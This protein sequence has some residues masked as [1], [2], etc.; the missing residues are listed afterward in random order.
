MLTWVT[1]WCGLDSQGSLGWRIR[2]DSGTGALYCHPALYTEQPR[3][4]SR[5]QEGLIW[6]HSCRNCFPTL[7]PKAKNIGCSL[8]NA[9]VCDTSS[10]LQD[11]HLSLL[12]CGQILYRLS[13]QGSPLRQP[14]KAK[15]MAPNWEMGTPRLRAIR[16]AVCQGQ[17]RDSNSST[18]LTP[19]A[20]FCFT[21]LCRTRESNRQIIPKPG[22]TWPLS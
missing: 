21:A 1:L 8:K 2:R 22:V 20:W 15:M 18:F 10:N 17:H 6:A 19:K 5:S 3:Y 11:I 9:F 13:H 4:S 14:S 12:H 7:F 16:R